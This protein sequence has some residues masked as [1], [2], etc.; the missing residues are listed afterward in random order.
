MLLV[1]AISV[2]GMSVAFPVAI[3]LALIIGVGWSFALHPVGNP[4]LLG[5]GCAAVV[6]A[7]IFDALAYKAHASGGAAASL[8]EA[9]PGMPATV[10]P[11]GKKKS[12]T[13]G[14]VIA[15]IS[16]VLMGSFYPLVE[17][18]KTGENG[19]GPYSSGLVFS[20]GV[21]LSTLVFNLFFMN[22]PLEGK[23]VE[24]VTYFRGSVRQHLLGLLGGALWYCGAISNFVAARA[25]GAA[26]VGP[27]VSYAM[28]QGATLISALWGLIVWK[29]FAGA[30]GKVKSFLAAM[31]FLFVVGLAAVSLAPVFRAR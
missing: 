18:S 31:L 11:K 22:L 1:G 13:K 9:S 4:I 29:E 27:A 21:F 7:I 24:L 5:A 3:G 2:A 10:K 15:V 17:M 6:G 16:G 25:E 8:T 23:P 14:V 20:I 28:G 19:L 26:Q 30:N 12:G